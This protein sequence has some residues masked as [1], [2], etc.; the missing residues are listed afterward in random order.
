MFGK[1]R[2]VEGDNQRL[3]GIEL[4][5][6]AAAGDREQRVGVEAV[7]REQTIG[8]GPVQRRF[9]GG[10]EQAGEGAPSERDE[11][12]GHQGFDFLLDAA[13][14]AVRVEGLAGEGLEGV[15][16]AGRR[17]FFRAEGGAWGRLRTS[18]FFFSTTHSTTSPRENSMAWARAEG[19]LTYH[20]WLVLRWISWTLVGKPMGAPFRDGEQPERGGQRAGLII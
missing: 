2:I 11:R 15:E 16:E 9:A 3:G 10:S 4:G 8:G 5:D 13:L 20:C 14:S 19:K 17:V 7:L 1:Q 12:G 18:W 6:E